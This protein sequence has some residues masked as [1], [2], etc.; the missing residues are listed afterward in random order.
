MIQVDFF[1]AHDIAKLFASLIGVP[2]FGRFIV[3]LSILLGG[4]L[5]GTS[6][7]VGFSLVDLVKEFHSKSNSDE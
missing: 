7:P 4:M 1:S 2:G 3:S 5:G 6:A